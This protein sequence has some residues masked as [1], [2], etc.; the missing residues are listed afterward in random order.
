METRESSNWRLSLLSDRR[1]F[2]AG[3]LAVL[4]G[5][6]VA[7]GQEVS[8]FDLSLLDEWL[9]PNDLFFVRDHAKTPGVT[10]HGWTVSIAGRVAE[11]CQLKAE[12][13]A[14][15][16]RKRLVATLDCADQPAG[17]G[18]VSN[19]E[20]TGVPLTSLLE[21]ARLHSD[22]RFV[23]LI[24]AD[25]NY[26]RTIPLAKASHADTLLADRMNGDRLPN[27]HGFP[28]R[29]II[30]GWYGADSVKWLRGIEVLADERPG[31]LG[32]PAQVNAAFS[33]PVD[34][35]VLL[36][37]RFV[38]RGVA[39]AGESRVRRVE[40]STDGGKS[41]QEA[42]FI[43]EARFY[44]WVRWHAEWKIAGK[45]KHTLMVRVTDNQGRT[46][47]AIELWQ[48]VRVTVV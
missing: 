43:D 41:W 16:S 30:P 8:S 17:G 3:A 19:A 35:A 37:R 33:R 42:K 26:A 39:W 45:G 46:R 11:P 28:V 2:L 14:N 47:S 5:R 13:L 32:G 40:V 6:M 24:G 34:G 29:A 38:L 12:E 31:E 22:A 36:G 44:T 48:Q 18:L 23:R 15:L 20:W 10:A 9:T 4:A 25:G 27:A 7:R 21:R 1:R